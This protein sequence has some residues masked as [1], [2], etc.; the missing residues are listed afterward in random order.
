MKTLKEYADFLYEN[1][2]KET[3]GAYLF[4]DGELERVDFSNG[5]FGLALGVEE[6][7]EFSK[8]LESLEVGTEYKVEYEN[9]LVK[10]AFLESPICNVANYFDGTTNGLSHYIQKNDYKLDVH[11]Q[12][13]MNID[14]IA[15]ILWE[16]FENDNNY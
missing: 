10:D 15:K 1:G 13:M 3:D 12:I 16:E 11:E 14:I 7:E 2:Y 6:T 4:L 9:Y 8:Y 5:E